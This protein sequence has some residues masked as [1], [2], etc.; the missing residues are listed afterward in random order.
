MGNKKSGRRLSFF[1]PYNFNVEGKK[2]N[3]QPIIR[4]QNT[5]RVRHFKERLLPHR[6]QNNSTI[7]YSQEQA[8]AAAAERVAEKTKEQEAQKERKAHKTR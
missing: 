3:P 8:T 5:I 7:P 6:K 1:F 4:F 2:Y